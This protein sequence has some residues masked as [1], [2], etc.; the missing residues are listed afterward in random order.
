MHL[1][2]LWIHLK[3]LTIK[4][5][6]ILKSINELTNK[7]LL[8]RS[9]FMPK[10]HLRQPGFTHNPCGTFTKNKEIVQNFKETGK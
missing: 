7:F 1:L 5:L 2:W 4:L 6:I 3:K 9:I 10:I 8:T